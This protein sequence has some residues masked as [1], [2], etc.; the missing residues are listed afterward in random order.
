MWEVPHFA[1]IQTSHRS[2]HT[3][4]RRQSQKPWFMPP[5]LTQVVQSPPHEIKGGWMVGEA[6]NRDIPWAMRGLDEDPVARDKT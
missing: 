3:C 2:Y 5:P 4:S 6:N 1:P